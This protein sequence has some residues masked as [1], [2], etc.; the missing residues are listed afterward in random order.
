MGFVVEADDA[1]AIGDEAVWKDGAVVGW[2]TSGGYCH[3][4]ECSYATGYV[5]SASIA[6]GAG[7]WEIEIL[8]ERRRAR[9][10][11]EPLFDPKGV[12]MLS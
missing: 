2:I 10:Q 6:T 7:N 12:R 4:V 1:D 9:L 8:G 3:H 5:D 11:A